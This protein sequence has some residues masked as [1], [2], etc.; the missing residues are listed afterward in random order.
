MIASP[1]W[2]NLV[3]IGGGSW[4]GRKPYKPYKCV[5]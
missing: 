2:C 3:C 5:V 1:F 4:C